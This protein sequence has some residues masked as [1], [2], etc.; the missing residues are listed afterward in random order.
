MSPASTSRKPNRQY[1]AEEK[2]NISCRL[3]RGG[4]IR[5]VAA[6]LGINVDACY[7]WRHETGQS[8]ARGKTTLAL[9]R[10]LE[11]MASS[12]SG[13]TRPGPGRYTTL[14]GTTAERP[15]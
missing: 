4:T 14:M 15:S 12:R 1:S 6:E 3:D 5:A 8:T 9:G 13:T 7:R 11:G 2:A 10:P